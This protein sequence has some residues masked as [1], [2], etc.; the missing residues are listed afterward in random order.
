MISCAFDILILPY[1]ESTLYVPPH[2][3]G[4]RWITSVGSRMSDQQVKQDR[5]S[6]T[7]A[8]YGPC[9]WEHE[10]DEIVLLYLPGGQ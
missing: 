8:G 5:R 7:I 4:M 9:G 1:K 6:Q 10:Q 3:I 2:S